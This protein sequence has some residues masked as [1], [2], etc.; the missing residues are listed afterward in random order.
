MGS[1]TQARQLRRVSI[2]IYQ[3]IASCTECFR[4]RIRK[5]AWRNRDALLCRFA[6]FL[7]VKHEFACV[8]EDRIRQCGCIR[9]SGQDHA[10]N[11]RG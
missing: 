3:K 7:S 2:G 10:T 1:R 9:D 6:C 11:H 4:I 8:F 5:S